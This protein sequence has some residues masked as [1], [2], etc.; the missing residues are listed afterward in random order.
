MQVVL[1]N[2]LEEKPK[3]LAALENFGQANQL[4]ALAIRAADLALEEHLT[5]VIDYGYN[6]SQ[7]HQIV[8]RFCLEQNELVIEV[9]DDGKPFDPLAQGEVDTSVPLEQKPIGGLGIHLMRSFMD[10][11]RYRREGNKNILQM[12]KRLGDG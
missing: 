2:R 10:G 1:T 12:R 6:D 9:E 4:P 5:N 3:V 8:V 7:P 11:L